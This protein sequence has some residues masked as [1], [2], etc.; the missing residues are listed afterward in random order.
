MIDSGFQKAGEFEL[1]LSI[2]G[3]T[4]QLSDTDT[5]FHI[6]LNEYAHLKGNQYFVTL[7]ENVSL[8]SI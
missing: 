7:I 2:G 4:N 3:Q 6:F 5:D 8:Q 1:F